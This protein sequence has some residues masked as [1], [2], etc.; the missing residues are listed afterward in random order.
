MVD[1]LQVVKPGKLTAWLSPSKSEALITKE[2]KCAVHSGAEGLRLLGLCWHTPRAQRLENLEFWYIKA[3]EQCPDSGTE[4]AK[5]NF[6]S[7]FLLH[8][9]SQLI[10]SATCNGG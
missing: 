10:D 4:R 2:A 6:S 7:A 8:Y 3:E 1:Y 9:D 5:I